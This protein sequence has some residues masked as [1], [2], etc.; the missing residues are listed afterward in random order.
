MGSQIRDS[1]F[2]LLLSMD[3]SRERLKNQVVSSLVDC[4][5]SLTCQGLNSNPK[6]FGSF[7]FISFSF[8]ESCL[9]VSWCAG[10]RCDMVGNDENRGRSR[11][12]GA[13]DWG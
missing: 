6:Y 8:V 1:N 2:V 7:T 10:G 12:H 11:R 5:E 3:S 9:I 4:D 13:E